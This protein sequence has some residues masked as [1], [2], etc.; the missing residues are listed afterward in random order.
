MAMV[1]F[2]RTRYRKLTHK[3]TPITEA[4]FPQL[5][6]MTKLYTDFKNGCVNRVLPAKVGN[7]QGRQAHIS[8][9]TS[10]GR[11][12]NIKHLMDLTSAGCVL[13]S[14]NNCVFVLTIS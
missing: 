7:P 5:E 14:P 10:Q 8:T 3:E 2:A 4:D 9:I 6:A 11:Q 13:R 1:H 12:S